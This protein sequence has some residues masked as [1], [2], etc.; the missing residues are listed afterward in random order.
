MCACLRKK[1]ERLLVRP[2]LKAVKVVMIVSVGT[3]CVGLD[4]ESVKVKPASLWLI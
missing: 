2:S 1:T 3:L 4:P